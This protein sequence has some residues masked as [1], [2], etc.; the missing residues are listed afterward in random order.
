MLSMEESLAVFNTDSPYEE[1]DDVKKCVA[2]MI[3]QFERQLMAQQQGAATDAQTDDNI[4]NIVDEHVDKILDYFDIKVEFEVVDDD[5]DDDDDEEP[6]MA[7]YSREFVEGDLADLDSGSYLLNLIRLSYDSEMEGVQDFAQSAQ[8]PIESAIQVLSGEY[9]LSDESAEEIAKSYPLLSEDLESAEEWLAIVEEE[10]DFEVDNSSYMDLNDSQVY[11][12]PV[13]PLDP[14][15]VGENSLVKRQLSRVN[16]R[17][18]EMEEKFSRMYL[19]EE[20]VRSLSALERQASELVSS[21]KLSPNEKVMLFGEG[22]NEEDRI[23]SFSKICEKENISYNQ[24]IDRIAS[25]LDLRS[26]SQAYGHFGQIIDNGF[27]NK[28]GG[29]SGQLYE[30]ADRY[31]QEHLLS[32][33][34]A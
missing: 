28:D 25:Y 15:Q 7:T 34:I 4:V 2:T 14:S 30:E 19:E 5:D 31:A 11:Q 29:T 6:D 12:S 1:I 23:G 26:K 8:I 17:L 18:G 13:V 33:N 16:S 24:Q 20:V 10:N 32:L 27:G 21:G 9:V 22:Q 3:M